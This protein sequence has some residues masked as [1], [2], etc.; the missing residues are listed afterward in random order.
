M[1]FNWLA[2]VQAIPWGQVIDNTPKLIEATRKLFTRSSQP[3]PPEPVPPPNL[4]SNDKEAWLEQQLAQTRAD[5]A[6]LQ[7][8]LQESVRLINGLA[9][10]NAQ[11]VLAI[12]RLRIRTRWFGFVAALAL[13][14][15]LGLALSGRLH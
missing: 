14:G 13:A 9:E 4:D 5:L 11:M 6:D 10:Q 3:L 7:H 12:E 8:D 2:A 1:P 15:V